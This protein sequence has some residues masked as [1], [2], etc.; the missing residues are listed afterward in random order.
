MAPIS[1]L[2]M[3]AKTKTP[4]RTQVLCEVL[5]RKRAVIRRELPRPASCR[6][7]VPRR[8][9][10]S[11][12]YHGRV[13]RVLDLDARA[14]CAADAAAHL[15]SLSAM[16]SRIF[17]HVRTVPDIGAA[18]MM[19]RPCRRESP[20]VTTGRVRRARATAH[21]QL[22]RIDDLAGD[23]DGVRPLW[24]I[25]PW[26]L[27]AL[28]VDAEPVGVAHATA[29][30]AAE[31]VP[32]STSLP[33]VLTED[34]VYA[35]ERAGGEVACADGDFLRRLEDETYFPMQLIAHIHEN[36]CGAELH[37]HVA[38]VATGMH[39]LVVLR[40]EGQFGLFRNR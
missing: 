13:G 35:V 29:R 9:H 21:E 38:I 32:A 16:K 23:D 4:G 34:G 37:G 10:A 18:G 24:G 5:A 1:G 20:T 15:R 12:V 3:P 28:D 19:L 17:F 40:C 27:H 25:D 22:Q 33:Y 2:L 6:W 7:P 26:A 36:A 14:I 11:V 8:G 30:L 31:N 39:D